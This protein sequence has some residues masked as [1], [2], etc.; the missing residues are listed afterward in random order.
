M[1]PTKP[2]RSLNLPLKQRLNFHL[3]GWL[4]CV[5]CVHIPLVKQN[6]RQDHPLQ[7]RQNQR[8]LGAVSTWVGEKM[9]E[10]H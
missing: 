4:T 5:S 1:S 8:R 3:Q 10:T 2:H 9:K 6:I 7:Q